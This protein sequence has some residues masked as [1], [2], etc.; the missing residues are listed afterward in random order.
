MSGVSLFKYFIFQ[1]EIHQRIPQTLWQKL[2]PFQ[3][4]GVRFVLRNG[5]RAL[6]GDEMGI[7]ILLKQFTHHIYHIAHSSKHR[8]HRTYLIYIKRSIL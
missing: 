4:T 5:G 6:I 2:M 3:H 1:G 8:L 7:F